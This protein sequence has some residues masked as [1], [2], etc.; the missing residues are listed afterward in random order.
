M[1]SSPYRTRD[2][3]NIPQWMIHLSS[4]YEFLLVIIFTS[5]LW[6]G[7]YGPNRSRP[8]ARHGFSREHGILAST[9]YPK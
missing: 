3:Y 6:I 7:S 4:A 5:P 9:G 2:I 1:S 8:H